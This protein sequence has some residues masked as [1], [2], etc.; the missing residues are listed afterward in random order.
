MPAAGDPIYASDV[1]TRVGTT[2]GTSDIAATSYSTEGVLDTVTISAVSGK[3]YKIQ[4]FTPYQGSVAADRFLVRIRTGT[5]I[6][7]VQLT[8][9]TAE[10]HAT[11]GVYDLII[12]AEWTASA[13]ASQSFCATA[14]RTAGSG[15]LTVKGASSQTRLLTVDVVNTP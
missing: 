8:Y 11:G 13:T 2:E 15:N 9:D 14:N 6:A 5:T 1:N 3:R 10:I 12:I 4:Y 7:G